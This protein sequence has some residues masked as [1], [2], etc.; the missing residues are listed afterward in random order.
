VRSCTARGIIASKSARASFVPSS[1]KLSKKYSLTMKLGRNFLGF[2]FTDVHK[3]LQWSAEVP[4]EFVRA[5]ANGAGCP[6]T[7]ITKANLSFRP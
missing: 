6:L 1:L 2:L 3:A 7:S 4:F 5:A